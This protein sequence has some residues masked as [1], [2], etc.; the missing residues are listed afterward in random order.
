MQR[1]IRAA[2]VAAAIVSSTAALADNIT[3]VTSFPKELT[4][5]YKRA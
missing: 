1:R 4:E 2:A 3:V 5:A